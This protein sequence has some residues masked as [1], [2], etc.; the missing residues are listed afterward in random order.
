MTRRTLPL[1][2]TA[3]LT[4]TVAACSGDIAPF[5]PNGGGGGGGTG[6]QPC[7]D[8]K[9]CC[10][11]EDLVC[12]GNID[13]VV[14]CTCDALWDC[15]KNPDKCERKRPKPPGGGDW[16][17]NWGE[18]AYTCSKKGTPG[19]PPPG[20]NGWNCTWN[21]AEAQWDCK[22]PPPNP[23]NNPNDKTW[24]CTVQNPQDK[25]ICEKKKGT[26]TPPPPPKQDA[27][28]PKADTTVPPKQDGGGPKV[29]P[30][31]W[32]WNCTTNADGKKTCTTDGGLPGGPSGGGTWNCH[33]GQNGFWIC[34]GENVP[35]GKP[36]GGGNGWLCKQETKSGKTIW[37]C[38]KPDIPNED[39]PPG[40]GIWACQKSTDVGGTKC[41]EVPQTPEP[42]G[43]TP[44]PGEVCVPGTKRW[45]DG[46][47]YCGWGQMTC[48][49]DGTWPTKWQNG[50]KIYDCKELSN[51]GRPNTLCAC[52]HFYYNGDCCERPDCIVPQGSKPQICGKSPGKL[53]DY[54]NPQTP[55]CNEGGAKCVVTNKGEAFCGRGCS[56]LT[57]CP[58]GYTCKKLSTK[59][60]SFHQCVPADNSCYY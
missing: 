13:G 8:Y 43:F 20:G 21:G 36:P 41:E 59:S 17:C 16:N 56:L 24:N 49:P 5:G 48:L 15:S 33:L 30:G 12:D 60:G 31:G 51:G 50:K 44:K 46:Y 23:P 3:A 14:V 6:D 32:N 54:C 42:P 40:G 29:P 39:T 55:E 52:Y 22:L 18:F 27:G 53:C 19:E 25:L 7:T 34:N 1:L 9:K 28:V 45:C 57:P 35:P 47:V 37:V 10:P 11:P 4:L 2:L 58:A 26:P 38:K